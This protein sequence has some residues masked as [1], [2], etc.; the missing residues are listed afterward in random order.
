MYGA[1]GPH[2]K[3]TVTIFNR[4]IARI[5]EAPSD[6]L[7]KEVFES[8]SLDVELESALE[9]LDLLHSFTLE[10]ETKITGLHGAHMS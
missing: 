9:V 1:G 4:V 8:K 7:S 10:P 5:E 2:Y 6:S 3:T